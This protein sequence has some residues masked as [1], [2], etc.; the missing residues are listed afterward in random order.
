MGCLLNG[1]GEGRISHYL[2]LSFPGGRRELTGG[3]DYDFSPASHGPLSPHSA[4]L[5]A[6]PP[7]VLPPLSLWLSSFL[8]L[9][10]GGHGVKGAPGNQDSFQ[11]FVFKSVFELKN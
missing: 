6:A 4:A 10:K 8:G 1:M 9:R 2:P 11:M 3:L 5:K 7:Q